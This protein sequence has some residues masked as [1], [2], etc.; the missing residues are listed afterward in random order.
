MAGRRLVDESVHA[1]FN[2]YGH[3]RSWPVFA[4]VNTIETGID[5]HEI[6]MPERRVST[7]MERGDDILIAA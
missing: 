6:H 1:P 7:G 3:D 5:Y 4:N 2:T